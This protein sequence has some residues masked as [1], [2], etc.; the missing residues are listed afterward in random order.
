VLQPKEVTLQQRPCGGGLWGT[1]AARL[2]LLR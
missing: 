2:R 1:M